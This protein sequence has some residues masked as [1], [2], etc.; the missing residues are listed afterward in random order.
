VGIRPVLVARKGTSAP[1]GVAVL[2][3]LRGLPALAA[4]YLP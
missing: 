2:E 3:D 4:A 1:P